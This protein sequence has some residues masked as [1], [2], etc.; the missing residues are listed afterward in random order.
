MTPPRISQ[1][2]TSIPCMLLPHICTKLMYRLRMFLWRLDGWWAAVAGAAVTEQVVCD[3][4]S[5]RVVPQLMLAVLDTSLR[6]EISASED[7]AG[8][9]QPLAL[10]FGCSQTPLKCALQCQ[11][12]ALGSPLAPLCSCLEPASSEARRHR[13]LFGCNRAVFTAGAERENMGAFTRG[14][15]GGGS[16]RPATLH[17]ENW[18]WYE[19][20]ISVVYGV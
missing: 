9:V 17:L 19:R 7:P 1:E 3:F 20:G 11:A 5:L 10:Q 18:E 16:H 13:P 14:G 6:Q 12:A 8:H 2:C 4:G 15:M